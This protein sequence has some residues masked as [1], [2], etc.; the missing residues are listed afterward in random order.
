MRLGLLRL[1]SLALLECRLRLRR[2]ST[3][4]LF[5][6]LC[7][8][9]FFL[10]PDVREGSTAF[11]IGGHRVLLNSAATALAS[12]MTGALLM[13]MLGFYLISNSLGRDA[14]TGVGRIIASTPVS[15]AGYL[16]GKFLGN[17][18]Y[19]GIVTACFMAACMGMHLIRGE[20]P[21]EPLVFIETYAALFLPLIPCLA[22]LALLFES[23]PFLSGRV[24]DVLYFVIC[25][26]LLT[27]P[28]IARGEGNSPG[29]ESYIDIAG[30]GFI[31]RGIT[32]VTR[33]TQFSI[34]IAPF[35]RSLPPVLFPGLAWNWGVLLPRIVSALPAVPVFAVAAA[36]FRRFDPAT[37]R[38]HR[39]RSRFSVA[40][41]WE[42]F[43]GGLRGRLIPRGGW[44]VGKSSLASAVALDL[45]LSLALT[46]VAVVVFLVFAASGLLAPVNILKTGF[47]PVMF[48]L[49]VPLLAA[50]PTRDRTGNTTGLILTVPLL[51]RHF[52]PWKLGS[53]LAL[54]LLTG[55][56]PL[57]R[58]AAADPAGALALLNGLVLIAA[59]STCFGILTGSPKTFSVLFLLFLYLVENSKTIPAFDFAGWNGVASPAILGSYAL[60]SLLL[61]AG[62]WMWSGWTMSREKFKN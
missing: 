62:A 50:V 38:E 54:A 8:S 47:L 42:R 22:A 27:L 24:G 3:S 11:Q 12:G 30:L 16:A 44:I 46:P 33:E 35:D 21:L 49:L 29:W 19:L 52:V 36:C 45:R 10:M 61:T 58:L 6:V 55:S 39:K 60:A 14:K 59:A 20:A 4:V 41:A 51:R 1:R 7:A 28:T 17:T 56:G 2:A 31:I 18:V 9:A 34:G 13:F 57:A 48:L 53:C 5:L 26:P 23:V 40:G 25:I 37:G 43:V 15:S 32:H